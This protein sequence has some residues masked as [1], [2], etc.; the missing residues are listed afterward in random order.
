MK[1][2][3]LIIAFAL[4]I[5]ARAATF[6]VNRSDLTHGLTHTAH[7]SVNIQ[8]T[9]GPD[10]IVESVTLSPPNP[11]SGEKADIDIVIKNQGDT[12]ITT[13]FRVNLYVDPADQPPGESTDYL[14]H[15]IHGL[16]LTPGGTMTWGRAGHTF[17]TA[18]PKIYVW[19]DPPWENRIAETNENNNLYPATSDP[20]TATPDPNP[21][22]TP[23]RPPPAEGDDVYEEDDV[24]ADAKVVPATGAEQLRTLTYDA[25]NELVDPDWIKVEVKANVTYYVRVD[26]NDDSP[27]ILYLTSTDR[28]DGP[29]AFAGGA[30]L[31]F[32]PSTDGTTY[33]EVGIEN[34]QE[35]GDANYRLTVTSDAGCEEFLEPNNLCRQSADIM[36]NG[37]AQNH[38]FCARGDEDWLKFEVTAGAEYKVTA[39]N[40]GAQADVNLTLFDSC[41]ATNAAASGPTL[42]YESPRTGFAYIKATNRDGGIHG[43]GTEYSVKV[44]PV[45]EERCQADA[46]EE[47]DERANSKEI[48]IGTSQ[49]RNVCPA[50]ESDWAQFSAVAGKTYTLETLN[51]GEA[52][53]TQLCLYDA[54]GTE[55]RC[56][57]DSGPD[58][59]ARII[60]ENA[61][62]N[63]T[64]FLKIDSYRANA[65]GTETGYALNVAEG[66]CTPDAQEPDNEQAAARKLTVDGQPIEHNFC[67][68]DDADWVSFDAA[69]NTPYLIETTPLG[70]DVD[71]IIELYD[72]DG[73]LLSGNDDY[74]PGTGS[75]IQHLAGTAST[76]YVRMRPF[77]PNSFGTGTEYSVSIRQGEV[78][79]TPTPTPTA[80]PAPAPTTTPSGETG[81]K[82]LILV[83]QPQLASMH[84]SDAAQV[85][86]LLARLNDLARHPDVGGEI[87]RLDRYP[88]VQRTYE[89]W[90]AAPTDVDAANQAAA[91]IRSVVLDQLNRDTGLQY[92]VLVGD[93]RVLPFR[94]IIDPSEQ[95]PESRYQ[96]VDE[97]NPTGAAMKA[98][99]Y[100]SDDYYADREPTLRDAREFYIPDVAIGRLIETPQ[101]MINTIDGFL[102]NPRL[103]RWE[104]AGQR[105]RL[106]GRSGGRSLQAVGE[107]LDRRQRQL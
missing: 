48:A 39:T 41:D 59:G 98:N 31:T 14:V 74:Q 71:T 57:D 21:S 51:F 88:S 36:A 13:P 81:T 87:V 32:T 56:D 105:L 68:N 12:V 22:P 70:A 45:G 54:H 43:Q 65:A 79:A 17:T 106:C 92:I 18:N 7:A 27:A 38:A 101:E 96:H 76:F 94:R 35:A 89:A 3:R 2:W 90:N 49:S 93:D 50:G 10:L 63:G 103:P 23:T 28:C 9:G 19:V 42:T 62:A 44:E 5:T 77:N 37:N 75:Q 20:P 91:A 53:D 61:P 97:S 46:Y 11:G 64:Y 67:P 66:P 34:P 40:T 85:D 69:A 95:F 99:Y 1:F 100:L 72:A 26:A 30:T 29:P 73:N 104:G 33:V 84:S 83:H 86:E 102:G 80:T 15:T 6:D 47:D 82:S 55:L 25:T 8:S 107:R 58:K 52:G 60:L 16:G 4:I 24:C 78:Q